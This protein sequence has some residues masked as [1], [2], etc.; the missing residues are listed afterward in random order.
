MHILSVSGLHVGLV[1]GGVLALVRLL[2]V[3]VL[4][5]APVVTAM[6]VLYATL[7]GLG[8]AVTRSTLM[9][10]MF[11]WANHL[12]RA[13]DWPTTLAAAALAGLMANPL[14]LYDIGFQLSFAS[15]WGIL[16]LGPVLDRLLKKIIRH[17]WLRGAL[18]VSL[19]A[20]LATLPLVARYYN[21]IS[22]VSL[23]TNLV[24]VPLTGL[25][26]GL[27]TASALLGL[28]VPVLAGFLNVSTS[29]LMDVFL[30]LVTLCRALPGSVIYVP[31][32]PFFL[33]AAWYP[34]LIAGV[35]LVSSG[36]RDALRGLYSRHHRLLP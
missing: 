7:C 23:L 15:T 18:W 6:L 25:I 9:A 29:L 13:R 5:T 26:L 24:A 3:P 34:L 28:V 10:L 20:Q 17:T 2:R 30:C 33:V 11:L 8:P 32:P 4:F 1:L 31:T 12:G 22:P 14:F 19:A 36:G 21:L 16:Y 27:G 35:L